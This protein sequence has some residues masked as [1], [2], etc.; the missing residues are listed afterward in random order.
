M[1]IELQS[2]DPIVR[3][4]AQRVVAIL[5]DPRLTRSERVRQVRRAQRQLLAYRAPRG[6]TG[7]CE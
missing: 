3:G 5:N 2:P 7:S 4:I 6:Q 1:F